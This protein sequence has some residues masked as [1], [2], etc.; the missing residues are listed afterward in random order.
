MLLGFISLLLTV[1]QNLI[2]KMC[3]PADIV[4]NMLPCKRI[5]TT[6]GGQESHATTTSHFQT[7]FSSS[8][9]GTARRLLAEGSES[10]V[11]YCAKKVNIIAY[12]I[13]LN[14]YYFSEFVLPSYHVLLRKTLHLCEISIDSFN[15]KNIMNYLFY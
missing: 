11:G 3:V 5:E 10:S 6:T 8:I 7:F 14:F 1:F 13:Y 12:C 4:D 9:S 2:A 15:G